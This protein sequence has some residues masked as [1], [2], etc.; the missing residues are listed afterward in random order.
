MFKFFLHRYKDW[1][2]VGLELGLT[3]GVLQKIYGQYR[4]KPDVAL[5][6]TI[7]HW[8]TSMPNPTW[9]SLSNSK[10][11][12]IIQVACK[13]TYT[14]QGT[15]KISVFLNWMGHWSRWLGSAS[16]V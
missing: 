14:V 10:C 11:Y 3:S 13:H 5:M 15:K 16:T 4:E 8:F 7:K 6:E 1:Y 12:G 9:E 2:E